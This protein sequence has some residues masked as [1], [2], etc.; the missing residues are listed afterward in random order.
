MSFSAPFKSTAFLAIVLFSAACAAS[1]EPAAEVAQ[2]TAA[3]GSPSDL[4]AAPTEAQATAAIPTETPPNTPTSE[5]RPTPQPAVDLPNL[6]PA[7]DIAN[8]VWLNTDRPLNLAA[9]QGEV[10]LV[11]FWTFG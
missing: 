5:P 3:T 9:L 8:E 1:S 2:P 6:G 10:V 7:P 4:T 11:E